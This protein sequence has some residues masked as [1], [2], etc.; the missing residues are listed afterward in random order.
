MLI[1][2]RRGASLLA[3]MLFV[4]TT[5]VVFGSIRASNGGDLHSALCSH[6]PATAQT[7]LP[8]QS[9]QLPESSSDAVVESLERALSEGKAEKAHDLLIQIL[10]RPHLTS[11]LL[12]RVGIQFAERELYPEAAEAF[13]RCVHEHPA[14]FEAYYNLVL[15]DVGQQK[16]TQA[17]VTLQ[18]A[19]QRSKAEASACSYLRGRIEDS[20]GETAAAEHDLSA[21]FEGAPQN[22]TYGLDLGLFNIRQRAYPQ[23]IAVFQR[24]EGYNPQSSFVLLG[25]SL[26][27]FLAGQQGQSV[28]DL[29]KLLV[30]EPGFSPAQLLL[31]FA[32]F[33]EGKLEDAEQVASEALNSPH[34]SPYLYYLDASILVK[35]QSR[36][37]NRI[38]KELLIARNNLP[39][40]S[41]CY[42]TE[43]KAHQAQGNVEA[44]IADLESA[45]SLDPDFP[46]AWYRLASLYRS[47]GRSADASRAQDHFQKLKVDKEERETQMLRDNFLKTMGASSPA[48]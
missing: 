13:E 22:E 47:A 26:A 35:L 17:L 24:A 1:D 18:G 15:A 40:C 42:M 28:E 36:Q 32:L 29:K 46:E 14:V 6:C 33:T 45:V 44:A 12:L 25:L 23:A 48:Q 19:P 37:Y 43:S 4:C 5:R 34:P 8:K 16:W 27:Q 21:A 38:F 3:V 9:E 41:L 20:Q 30:M 39:S 7:F 10:K 2:P 11:D 31:T